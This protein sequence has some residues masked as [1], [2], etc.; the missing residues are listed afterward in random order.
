[1]ATVREPVFFVGSVLIIVT[2]L[3]AISCVAAQALLARWW[4]TAGGRHVMAFQSVVAA[5]ASLWALR[6]W[7]PDAEWILVARFVAFACLPPVLA[8]R[9]AIIV[10]TWRD[11]RRQHPRE[12]G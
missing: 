9:L 2:A 8:W 5:L 3:L 12:E 11:K 7:L 10:R 4:E 1:V 6:V